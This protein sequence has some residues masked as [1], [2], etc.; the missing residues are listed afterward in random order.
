M[1]R[2]IAVVAVL[3]ILV[4]TL[5]VGHALQGADRVIVNHVHSAVYHPPRV[6]PTF[7]T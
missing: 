6:R 4:G 2:L 5:L 1:R 7:R 3:A